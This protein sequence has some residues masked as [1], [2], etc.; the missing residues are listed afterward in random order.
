MTVPYLPLP[1]SARGERSCRFVAFLAVC[2]FA[3]G[4]VFGY[5]FHASLSPGFIRP[6]V[7]LGADMP[8]AS[9]AE[10]LPLGSAKA[11][12]SNQMVAAVQGIQRALEQM[13][14]HKSHVF[15][16]QQPPPEQKVSKQS[17]FN[18]IE[19]LQK[20]SMFRSKS[21]KIKLSTPQ[22]SV[23]SSTSMLTKTEVGGAKEKLRQTLDNLREKKTKEIDNQ[24]TK[25]Q[26]IIKEFPET[27]QVEAGENVVSSE[28]DKESEDL[29]TSFDADFQDA[30]GEDPLDGVLQLYSN[31]Q[32]FGNAAAIQ[33]KQYI[34]DTVEELKTEA[35]DVHVKMVLKAALVKFFFSS[36]P[37][38]FGFAPAPEFLTKME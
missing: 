4:F 37:W 23:T 18:D 21:Q 33:T 9:A 10:M 14:R 26:N 2:I 25:M 8:E 22:D 3:T 31:A 12:S 11:V 32:S 13:A 6:A 19:N 17:I 34:V 15:V 35:K 27:E 38:I 36:A 5:A 29:F 7:A 24:I 30:I 16:P 28:M 1:V 20:P